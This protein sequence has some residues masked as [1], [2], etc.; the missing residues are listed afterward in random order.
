MGQEDLLGLNT[1][2]IISQA[3]TWLGEPVIFSHILLKL[4][5]NEFSLYLSSDMIVYGSAFALIY[6]I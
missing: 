5:T 1:N 3:G 4:Q 6:K 2:H